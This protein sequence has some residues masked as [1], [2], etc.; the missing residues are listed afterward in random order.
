MANVEV[1]MEEPPLR[2]KTKG[3]RMHNAGGDATSKRLTHG[4]GEC[5]HE[6]A[7]TAINSALCR[8]L[9]YADALDDPGDFFKLKV[10]INKYKKISIFLFF[11]FLFLLMD[12]I[13]HTSCTYCNCHLK[14]MLIREGLGILFQ[15]KII[16]PKPCP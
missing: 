12:C 2:D 5:W 10:H 9:L 6:N 14:K 16:I 11:S 13:A 7:V 1:R 8:A 4:R 3:R 15:S